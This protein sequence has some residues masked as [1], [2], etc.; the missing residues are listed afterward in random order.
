MLLGY[1]FI[2]DHLMEV[3]EKSEVLNV[4]EH[5]IVK[6]LHGVAVMLCMIKKS[7]KTKN[8]LGLIYN[9]EMIFQSRKQ[10]SHTLEIRLFKTIYSI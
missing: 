8:G 3:A 9:S 2:D 4:D 7:E 6:S 5:Y 10:R 1:T